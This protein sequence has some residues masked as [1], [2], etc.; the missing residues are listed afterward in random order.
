[1]TATSTDVEDF[2]FFDADNHIYEPPEAL[3]KH[4]PA[5]YASRL[6][7]LRDG[8]RDVISIQGRTIDYIPNPTFAVVAAPGAFVDYYSA[9]NPDGRSLREMAGNPIRPPGAF[10]NDPAA[11]LALLDEQ[12]VDHVLVYPTLA[13]LVEQSV[14]NDP[15]LTHA[16]IHSLNE[17]LHETWTFDYHD[18]IYMVPVLTLGMVDKAIEELEWV[19]ERGA[20]AILIRPAPPEGFRGHR[21]FGL[22]EFDPFWARVQEADIPVCIHAAHSII[23]GY[24]HLWEP[25]GVTS[26]FGRTSFHNVVKGHRDIHDAIASL[27]CH[28]TLTRFPGLRV[29]S[30][31]NGADWVG[32]LVH[33]LDRSYRMEP[34]QHD[35][36]PLEVLRRNIYVSPFWEDDLRSVCD[37]IGVERIVFGSDYPHPEGLAN[38]REYLAQLDGFTDA[39]KRLILHDN[40]IRLVGGPAVAT[41]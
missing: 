40:A 41:P 8:K 22:P 26:A 12:G 15:E 35:E 16:I 32:Q 25:E 2:H 13:N 29:A 21:S 37:L 17:W 5:R 3:L 1:M 23:E 36:H 34:Q 7:F 19:L 18:R 38:P 10:Q 4:L 24:V 33:A 6:R 31:E 39:E 30:V 11:R 14:E 20:R 27:I 28:G 9:N